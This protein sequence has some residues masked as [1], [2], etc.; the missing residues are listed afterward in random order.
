M[1]NVVKFD[2]NR[3]IKK[4]PTRYASQ[5]DDFDGPVVIVL[6]EDAET[7]DLL[8]SIGFNSAGFTNIG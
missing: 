2:Q 6:I 3:K 4:C 7:S 8:R 1:D 5:H